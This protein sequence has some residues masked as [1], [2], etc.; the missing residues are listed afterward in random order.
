MKPVGYNRYRRERKND[1][2]RG[3]TKFI[4]QTGPDALALYLHVNSGLFRTSALISRNIDT[5]P[6]NRPIRVSWIVAKVASCCPRD[7]GKEGK[8][9]GESEFHVESV[10]ISKL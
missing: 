5:R 1:V 9:T 2:V 4:L 6:S 3:M 10:E 7:N 8:N